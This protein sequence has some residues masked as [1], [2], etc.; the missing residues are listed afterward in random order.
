MF[1]PIL[2]GPPFTIEVFEEESEDRLTVTVPL[3]QCDATS[4]IVTIDSHLAETWVDEFF[5]EFSFEITV[6][7]FW[8]DEPPFTTQNRNMAAPYIPTGIRSLVMD[9][10]CESCRSLITAGKPDRI[11]RVTKERHPPEPALR[12]HHMLTAVIQDC[13]YAMVRSGTDS[14]GRVFWMMDRI[15]R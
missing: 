4:S 2:A 13:G 6:T 12:K 8:D 3:A 1:V 7:S 10:V 9:V 14:W 11:Y 5:H 15:R